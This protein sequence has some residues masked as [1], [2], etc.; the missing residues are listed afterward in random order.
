MAIAVYSLASKGLDE[1]VLS[2]DAGRSDRQ[3][4][5]GG[6]YRRY[7]GELCQYLRAKYGDGPPEAED[8]AQAA[9]AKVA[10]L[11]NVGSIKNPRAYLYRVARNIRVDQCRRAATHDRFIAQEVHVGG[12]KD[13]AE[14]EPER[15]LIGKEEFAVLEAAIRN[16]DQRE[17]D[18]LLLHRLHN[19]GYT[20]IARR[21]GM[22]RNGV[23]AV[24][25]RAF[26]K[27]EAAMRQA[28]A[29]NGT[30]TRIN[31]GIQR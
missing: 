16:L 18:F 23:K 7:W 10:E 4:V 15:V 26:A 30:P 2:D 31:T 21:V 13:G 29:M 8:V 12:A 24:I 6:L 20:D 9:F 14:I 28:G 5:L 25:E 3:G 17:R 22:S 11:D 1:L 19:L 27:C